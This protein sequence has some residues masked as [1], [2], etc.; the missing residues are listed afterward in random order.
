MSERD[1]RIEDWAVSLAD[2]YQPPEVQRATLVGRV[3]GHPKHADGTWMRTSGIYEAEGRRVRTANTWY[4]LGEPS[5]AYLVWLREHGRELD[6]EQPV[7][8]TEGA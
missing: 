4:V 6:P 5:E 8:I 2:P 1:V 3:F 7:L